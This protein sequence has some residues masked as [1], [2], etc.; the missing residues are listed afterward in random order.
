MANSSAFGAFSR[1]AVPLG[2]VWTLAI[3]GSLAWNVHEQKLTTIELAKAQARE[4][5]DKDVAYRLWNAKHWGVYVRVQ[6]GTEPNAYLKE[7]DRDLNTVSG[8]RLTLV[9]PAYMTRQVFEL[10]EKSS[11]FRGHITSLKPLRP[12][13]APDAWEAAALESF[14]SGVKETA[15]VEALEG[16]EYMRLIKPL[17]TE[18]ECLKCHAEQGYKTGDVRGGISVAVPMAPL[19]EVS[20]ERS[21]ALWF[22]H[23]GIWGAGMAGIMG[24]TLLVH[25]Q[26]RRRNVA[27]YLANVR[28][29]ALDQAANPIVITGRD[30][31][32]EYIN[33]AFTR[34]TGFTIRDCQD[35]TPRIL[36]SGKQDG[37]FYQ[38][39]W[40]LILTGHVWEGELTNRKKDGTLYTDDVTITPVKDMFG[41]IEHFIAVQQDVSLRKN[42]EYDSLSRAEELALPYQIGELIARAKN[43]GELLEGALDLLLKMQECTEGGK[44]IVFLMDHKAG[45]LRWAHSRGMFSPDFLEDEQFVPLG[46][47]I[48]GKAAQSG[49][50]LVC[51]DCLS[52]P[53]HENRWMGMK[54][55]GH[56][57]IPLTAE[58][59]VLGVI[60]LYTRTGVHSDPRRMEF[61]AR[62]GAMIG[63]ALA[64][65]PGTEL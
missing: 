47:C 37:L 5:F 21:R 27:E 15:S 28:T 20:R 35:K 16:T 44:G 51:D 59:R 4:S 23:G 18:P 55:H 52:D 10:I 60:T 50:V 49:H 39:M 32:I 54:N 26:G 46:R 45:G 58:N 56:Y 8:E 19:W 53:R 14:E 62:L 2:I 12:Q 1:F 11:G 34:L 42:A 65:I 64:R 31:I 38:S 40:Q 57:A 17:V 3:V 29:A 7:A 41:K 24:G 22:G 25:R 61:L 9:N 48:C 43:P 30:G 36:K 13:N 63:S 33:P 6:D